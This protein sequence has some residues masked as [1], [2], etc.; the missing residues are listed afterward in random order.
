MNWL[1]ELFDR[2]LAWLPRPTLLD[3]SE[4]GLK[5]SHGKL[6]VLEGGKRYWYVPLFQDIKTFPVVEQTAD[7][8]AQ[9]LM[10]ANKK[11]LLVSGIVVYEV[12]DVLTV[13][14]RA[15]DVDDIVA[16]V[17]RA[18]IAEVLTGQPFQTLLDGQRDGSTARALAVTLRR[19]LKRLS[20]T[21]PGSDRSRTLKPPAAG[22][23]PRLNGANEELR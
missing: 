18:T 10:S 22:S 15:H 3:P 19:R 4:G 13:L 14:T 11:P 6:R 23:E 8:P 21:P 12:T 7:L 16:D 17:G 9:T 2:M 20:S 5:I 1:V